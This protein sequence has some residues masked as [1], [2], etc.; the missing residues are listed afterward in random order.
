MKRILVFVFGIFLVKAMCVGATSEPEH[1]HVYTAGIEAVYDEMKVGS[2]SYEASEYTWIQSTT[3]CSYN[4]FASLACNLWLNDS[5]K[6][7]HLVIAY[8]YSYIE[9]ERGIWQGQY[10]WLDEYKH[11]D[12]S[13][14]QNW[15]FSASLLDNCRPSD[16]VV[17]I[18][19]NDTPPNH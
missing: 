11:P 5:Y 16:M 9:A 19:Y 2:W 3:I 15:S 4:V 6:Q 10:L 8:A 7:S 13:S 18:C 14:G 12:L 17:F 1:Y